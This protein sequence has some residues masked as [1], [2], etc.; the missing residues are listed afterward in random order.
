MSGIESNLSLHLVRKLLF[1]SGETETH[2]IGCRSENDGD[3]TWL[4]VLPGPQPEHL[5]IGNTQPFECG[6]QFGRGVCSEW[7]LYLFVRLSLEAIHQLAL[8]THA[9]PMV[10]E[11]TLRNAVRPGKHRIGWDI[12]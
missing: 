5:A 12:V 11:R 2:R 7:L 4:E 9:A 10:R 6:R 1:C 3:L 8:A